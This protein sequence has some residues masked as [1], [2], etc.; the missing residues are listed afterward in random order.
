MLKE[1][2]K[3]REY[4]WKLMDERGVAKFPLPPH[5]RIPNF[6]GAE[7]TA[8]KIRNL[9]VYKKANVIKVS[10]DS[11]QK[12]IRMAILS[13]DKTLV[14]PTPRLRGGFILI[15]GRSVSGN[16]SFIATIKGALRYGK[17]VYPDELPEV[18]LI[19]TGSVAVTLNGRRLGKGGG[20]SELEYGI[21]RELNKVDDNIPI[22]S[23]IHE[24][25]IVNWIPRDPYDI[26]LDYIVTPKRIVRVEGREPRP[27]GILW[28]YITKEMLES[29]PVIKWLSKIKMK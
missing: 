26:T 19:I 3:I 20:Y 8:V 1:K 21:L 7:E 2:S 27:Q 5:G 17:E 25:Q 10:P 14:M 28:K 9:D 6:I 24:L 11:P 4:I 13:D 29:K 22:I 12:P 18:N 23:N 16:L 15:D